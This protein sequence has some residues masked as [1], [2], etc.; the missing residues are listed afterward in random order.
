MFGVMN[1]KGFRLSISRL[2]FRRKRTPPRPERRLGLVEAIGQAAVRL[3]RGRALTRS[4]RWRAAET[5]AGG[6]APLRF[7][8][9]RSDLL[10]SARLRFEKRIAALRRFV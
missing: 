9:L 2:L 8:P 6:C 1:P 10:R 4:P 5:S 7:A 3:G